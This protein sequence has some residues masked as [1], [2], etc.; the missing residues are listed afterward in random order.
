MVELLLAERYAELERQLTNIDM[1]LAGK[2]VTP[3]E[4]KAVSP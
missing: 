1:T 3:V 2:A 4:R